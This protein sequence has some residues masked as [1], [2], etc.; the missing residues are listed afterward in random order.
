MPNSAAQYS[1]EY[2]TADQMASSLTA[3][4][5]VLLELFGKCTFNVCYGF[6]ANL[7]TDLYYVPMRVQTDVMPYFIE[8]SIRQRIIIPGQS[9][10]LIRSPH[11][12]LELLFCHESD[13]HVNGESVDLM[14]RFVAAEPF[15][16]LRFYSQAE[17]ARPGESPCG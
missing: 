3:L 4:P 7:H 6:G 14:R 13:I 5:G 8:E 12:E 15:S 1:S 17:L 9:D 11:N 10:L 2:L 16:K